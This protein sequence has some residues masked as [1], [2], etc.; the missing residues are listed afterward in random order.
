I[1]VTASHAIAIAIAF[2]LITYITVILGEILPKALALQ[3]GER[4][5]LAVAGPMDIFIAIAGP[6]LRIM[7]GSAGRVLKLF[8]IRDLREGHAHSTEELKFIV[9]GAHR[10][11]LM[12][13]FQEEVVLR[14]LDLGNISVREIMTPRNRIFALPADMHLH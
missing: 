2:A 14:A 12:P 7:R 3:R 11:G 8:G 13:E 6:F 9:T 4:V 5:A 10:L 1:V